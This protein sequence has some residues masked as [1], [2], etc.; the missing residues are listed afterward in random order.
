MNELPKKPS[1]CNC[2]FPNVI[3]RN[4]SGHATYC[5]CHKEYLE[6][7]NMVKA[8]PYSQRVIVILIH[9]RHTDDKI[10]VLEYSNKT[11]DKA[12]EICRNAFP[13]GKEYNFEGDWCWFLGE[14]YLAYYVVKEIE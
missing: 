13:G 3:Y 7:Y 1:N 10:R 8:N 11:I 2:N 14:D 6:R 9:D 5:P 4:G 12:R